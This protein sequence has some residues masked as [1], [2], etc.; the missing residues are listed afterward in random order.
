MLER[1][2]RV[3]GGK[4][5]GDAQAAGPPGT[6]SIGPAALRRDLGRALLPPVVEQGGEEHGFVVHRVRQFAQAM[7]RDVR[8]RRDEIEVPINGGAHGSEDREESGTG[9]SFARARRIRKRSV[10][11]GYRGGNGGR[12]CRMGSREKAGGLGWFR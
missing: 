8:I 6:P 7:Q 9:G 12:A 11:S 2:E 4:P 1:V 5:E 10:S 3:L